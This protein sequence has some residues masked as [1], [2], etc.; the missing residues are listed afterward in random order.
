MS[1]DDAFAKIQEGNGL[2]TDPSA[3]SLDYLDAVLV[4]SKLS[5]SIPAEDKRRSLFASNAVEYLL[6]V[7][8]IL[9]LKATVT[10]Q[11]SA[12]PAYPVPELDRLP[13]VPKSSVT[14]KADDPSSSSSSSSAAP[15]MT[16]EERL[17]R[18]K[19]DP[20]PSSSPQPAVSDLEARMAALGCNYKGSKPTAV[21]DYTNAVESVDDLM[22]KAIDEAKLDGDG[23][24]A[25]GVGVGVSADGGGGSGGGSSDVLSGESYEEIM[26]SVVGE[27]DLIADL[28]SDIAANDE[29]NAAN[30]DEATA[31]LDP[32]VLAAIGNVN[33]VLVQAAG[34]SDKVELAKLLDEAKSLLS[35]IK[36]T[37]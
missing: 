34:T 20:Q 25:V 30:E 29:A 6:K 10:N 31:E 17:A 27:S 18:L 11:L 37:S 7:D 15:P 19:T 8:D 33:N 1:L 9:D 5:M 16:L 2:S 12:P 32:V 3:A 14:S 4:L 23:I 21:P 26:T 36:I 13:S 28:N 22:A 35:G 24:V